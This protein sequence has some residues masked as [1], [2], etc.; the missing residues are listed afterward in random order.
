MPQAE[1]QSWT[2]DHNATELSNYH[3][4]SRLAIVSLLVG[5]ASALAWLGP[6]MWWFPVG[7]IAISVASLIHVNRPN[8]EL[9]GRKAAMFG[10]CLALI[11]GIGAPTRYYAYRYLV[12]QE[13]ERFAMQWFDYLRKGEFEKAHQMT[14]VITQ[15]QPLDESL[16]D[17][18]R[19]RSDWATKLREYTNTPIVRTLLALGD[20]AEARLH[21]R[22]GVAVYPRADAVVDQFAVTYE[23]DGVKKSFFLV[24]FLERHFNAFVGRGQWRI[25]NMV[26]QGIESPRLE[27]DA[28][29]TH[30]DDVPRQ[31]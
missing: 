1:M 18:Y 2:E 9:I 21:K 13:G 14:V 12:Q 30:K 28:H 26:V 8:S 5:I 31:D 19:E 15:R 3:S 17:F 7:A 20:R 10:L 25:T 16:W 4:V 29:A 27:E 24:L 6:Y 22:L 23:E 11:S